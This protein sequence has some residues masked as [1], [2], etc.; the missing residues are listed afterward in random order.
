MKKLNYWKHKQSGREGKQ[1]SS[2]FNPA[3]NSI[4]VQSGEQF[5]QIIIMDINQKIMQRLN[6][7]PGTVKIDEDRLA[8]GIYFI[9]LI[10]DDVAVTEKFIKQ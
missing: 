3:D 4:T 8:S 5:R 9:K 1:W 7:E 10:G 2:V 6:K